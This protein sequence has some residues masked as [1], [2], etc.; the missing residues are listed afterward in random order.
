MIDIGKLTP[1]PFCGGEAE[2][3]RRGTGRYSTICRCTECGCSLETGETFD[4]GRTWNSRPYLNEIARRDAEIQ[5]LRE[6]NARLEGALR[7]LVEEMSL[8]LRG[9]PTYRDWTCTVERETYAR[10]KTL[11]E[12]RS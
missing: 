9:E 11:L 8:P 1:C 2:V 5:A 4:H 12:G 3:E 6:E 10:A 7:A